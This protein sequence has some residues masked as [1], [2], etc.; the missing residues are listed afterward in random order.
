M[1]GWS[2]LVEVLERTAKMGII[3]DET[4]INHLHCGR[5]AFL[6]AA[7]TP[8]ETHDIERVRTNLDGAYTQQALDAYLARYDEQEIVCSPP[9]L[10]ATVVSGP[11]I[12]VNVTAAVGNVRSRVQLL[13]RVEHGGGNGVPSYVPVMFVRN[14]KITQQDKLLLAFRAHALALALGVLPAEAR[15]VHGDEYRVLKVR[16]EPL[17]G[18][19]QGLIEQI[20]ADLRRSE[21]PK[22]TLIGHCNECEFRSGCREIAEATDDL[23][24]LRGLYGKELNKL[25]SGGPLRLLSSRTPIGPAVGASG[26]RERLAS[27]TSPS[28][29]W[30]S[31]SRRSSS[32]TGRRCRSRTSP[33][34]STSRECPTGTPTT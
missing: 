19:V 24:L 7:R 20:E 28:R 16:I 33:S 30:P 6:K 34:T 10:E 12:I 29:R 21:P 22:L 9:S 32:S 5:K 18:R 23:S 26:E 13:Q 3:T 17:V 4:F 2:W 15:I 1:A 8:G 31:A 11:R 27:T 14:N 25:H